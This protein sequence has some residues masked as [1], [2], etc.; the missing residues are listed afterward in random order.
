MDRSDAIFLCETAVRVS[1][2]SESGV[3]DRRS[4]QNCVILFCIIIEIY[5]ESHFLMKKTL[6]ILAETY[7]MDTRVYMAD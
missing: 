4:N 6:W 2:L 5:K 3:M 7:C 1:A